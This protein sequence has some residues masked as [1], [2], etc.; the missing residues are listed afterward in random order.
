MAN[1]FPK[2]Q[3]LWLILSS[4]NP[5]QKPGLGVLTVLGSLSEC[6]Q[7]ICRICA[8]V[9]PPVSTYGVRHIFCQH[10]RI[11]FSDVSFI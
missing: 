10:Q 6:Q 8:F 11:Q 5:T 9:I 3:K 7:N 2:W 4:R 1:F